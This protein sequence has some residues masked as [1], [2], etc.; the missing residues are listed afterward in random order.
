MISYYRALQ[1]RKDAEGDEGFTLIEL[2]IVIIVLGILAAVVIFAL[3]N[4]TGNAKASACNADAKTVE[5]AVAAYN[6]D[7]STTGLSSIGTE[8]ST[9]TADLTATCS[10]GSTTIPSGDIEIGCSNTF[11]GATNAAQLLSSS[12]TSG[13]SAWPQS[14]AT[15]SSNNGYAISLASVDQACSTT[16]VA[17]CGT[18]SPSNTNAGLGAK[19]GQVIV[20]T[21]SAFTA[22]TAN[23]LAGSA[24]A[25]TAAEQ[26]NTGVVYD[27]QTGTNGCNAL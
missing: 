18:S 1:A 7:P 17:T 14:T 3:A 2:L 19:A 4:V 5:T 12:T 13:I 22:A 10:G 6:A 9:P 27:S 26:Y 23:N 21:G 16:A 11:Y 24:T 20:Y 25:P 8:T 15:E